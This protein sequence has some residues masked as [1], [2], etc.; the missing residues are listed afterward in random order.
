VRQSTL[1]AI[2]LGGLVAG[3][4]DIGAASL[5]NWLSL[6]LICKFVAGGLLGKAALQGGMDVA[7]YGMVL[8]WV[9]SLIIATVYVS[10]AEWLPILK[11][12]W[13]VFGLA[14]GVGIFFVMNYVVVPLS[15][16]H[17]W[18]HMAPDKF[19]E[20]MAAMLLFGVIV[21]FFARREAN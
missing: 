17:R 1:N 9:E 2:V 3:T 8:Q 7:A 12:Q 11:R 18:P 10:A 16:W 14:Y 15:A 6:V 5:I 21:A 13:I 20:N 19:A 4:V